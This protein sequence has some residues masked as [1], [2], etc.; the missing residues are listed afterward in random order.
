MSNKM[1]SLYDLRRQ[2]DEIDNDIHDLLMRR[3]EL[4]RQIG[5]A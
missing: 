1:P 5:V 3:T 2:I 4:A